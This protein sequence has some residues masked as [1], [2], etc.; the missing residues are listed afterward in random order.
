MIRRKLAV[1]DETIRANNK[2]FVQEYFS[3]TLDL[4]GSLRQPSFLKI[5]SSVALQQPPMPV[6]SRDKNLKLFCR[7][8]LGH[9]IMAGLTISG[10]SR[11]HQLSGTSLLRPFVQKLVKCFKSRNLAIIFGKIYSQK[12]FIFWSQFVI[13]RMP[14][15]WSQI[16]V[17]NP[18]V[19][20]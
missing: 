7:Q 17:P 12:S 18:R 10:N 2:F 13:A 19:P 5:L 4:L 11:W 20:D 16:D 3:A 1:R 6:P 8:W 14:R 15:V 9:K